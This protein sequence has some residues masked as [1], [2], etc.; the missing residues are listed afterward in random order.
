[1]AGLTPIATPSW[2]RRAV[3]T[4]APSQA[5]ARVARD[6]VLVAL[7]G[8]IERAVGIATALALRWG[9]DA[10]TLGVYTALRLFLD[11]T[12]RASLGVGHGAAREIPLL[13]AQGREAEAARV[14]NVAH[15]FNTI[16][17]VVYALALAG[18]A[19]IRAHTRVEDPVALEW[20]GGLLAVAGL[21]LLK[22]HESF[23]IVLLRARDRFAL[24]AELDLFEAVVSVVAFGLGLRLAGIWGLWIAVGAITI[25]KIIYIQ[26]RHPIHLAWTFDPVAT[27]GLMR[28]GLPILANVAVFGAVVAIDRAVILARLPDSSRML[29]LYTVAILGTNWSLDVAG[30]VVLVLYNSF[31]ATLGR[32]RDVVA[33]ARDAARAIEA[34]APWT[35]ACGAAV[36]VVGPALLGRLFPRYLEG[37][38]A[39][40]A[41]IPGAV[42]IGLAS[43]PRQLLIALGRP[44]RLFLATIAALAVAALAATLGARHAGLVGVAVGTSIGYAFVWVATDAVAFVP[45]LGIRGWLAHLARTLATLAY[46][47][48]AAALA[49]IAPL[50]VPARGAVV[51]A[52]VAPLL[53]PPLVRH[54]KS[55]SDQ[56]GTS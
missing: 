20:T 21:A 49:N 6:S 48:V 25:S 36:Y 50:P 16:A 42:V 15:T 55:T 27:W 14:A 8:Q 40:R 47:A 51:A 7:V 43:A 2:Q 35:A 26:A 23:L 39:L 45:A 4:A 46:C 12:N 11:N 56:A 22:R 3:A 30:R 1:M 29:G 54:H 19:G 41:L 44:L 24:T 13:I 33:V 38:P 9:L 37:L 32:T 5:R 10:T 17:C 28:V 53:I 52:I 34:Q 31:L 18:W